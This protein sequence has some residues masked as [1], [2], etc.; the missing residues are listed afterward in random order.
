MDNREIP[1]LVGAKLHGRF[2]STQVAAIGTYMDDETGVAPRTGLGVIRIRQDVLEE[3]SAG[4]IATMGDP[5]NRSGAWTTGADFIYQTSRFLGDKNFLVGVW[6]LTMDRDGHSP[7]DRSAF[8]LKID[9][10]ND[11]LDAKFSY[12]GIGEEFEPSL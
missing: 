6:G 3:S 2:N 5:L 8:G 11:S 10:P 12:K 7:L 4:F 9:Y 1:L